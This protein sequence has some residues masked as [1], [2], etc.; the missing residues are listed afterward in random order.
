MTKIYY[1]SGT[2]NTYWSA[3][4]LAEKFDAAE[5]VPIQKI[6]A[7]M[8]ETMTEKSV[9][10][11]E[12]DSVVFM[13][14]AYAYGIPVMMRRFIER[15]E[16][17]AP[18]IEACADIRAPYIAALVTYGSSPGGA[19]A[20]A[21]RVLRKKNL[22]LSY[23][24]RI[25]AVENYIPIFGAQSEKM[26]RKRLALQVAATEKA[27]AAIKEL[28]TKSVLTFHPFA[29]FVTALFRL[30]VSG[31]D[32]LFTLDSACNGCGFCASVCPAHAITM[33]ENHP[34]F[35]RG[36]E[37]CQACLNFCPQHAINFGRMKK[38]TAR[39]HHPE[40]SAAELFGV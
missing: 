14:P 5:M 22:R 18:C 11:I 29:S 1:F 9:I 24:G 40:V 33:S 6:M 25:P 13:F 32:G 26:Q 17:R 39:Y 15:A 21:T 3:K 7:K 34:V 16:I 4:K 31:M 37:Q 28:S 27:A 10:S 23:A 12:A 8:T 2:G 20:E 30:A 38:N 19:L 35:A 36:C